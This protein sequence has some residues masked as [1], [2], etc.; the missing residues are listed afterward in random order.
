MGGGE[1][2]FVVGEGV[3][4][5]VVGVGVGWPVTGGGDGGGEGSTVVGGLV[6]S[7]SLVGGDVI[8]MS[9]KP[10]CHSEE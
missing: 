8:V 3:G 4:F 5:S 7:T 6:D 9:S 2:A 10:R 1:G